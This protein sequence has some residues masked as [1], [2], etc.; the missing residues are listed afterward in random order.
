MGKKGD[1]CSCFVIFGRSPE[2][3]RK[4]AVALGARG[5]KVS[6]LV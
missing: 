1:A 4:E 3:G 2:Y 5:K 6:V